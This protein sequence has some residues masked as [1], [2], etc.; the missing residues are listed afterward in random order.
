MTYITSANVHY[1]SNSCTEWLQ[2][3][4]YLATTNTKKSMRTMCLLGSHHHGNK[5]FNIQTHAA[6]FLEGNGKW[7]ILAHCNLLYAG[8]NA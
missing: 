3:A 7:L 2:A 4:C 6:Q 5:I 1:R 8:S